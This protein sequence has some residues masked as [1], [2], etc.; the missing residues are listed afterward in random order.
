MGNYV[1]QVVHSRFP[2]SERFGRYSRGKALD[3]GPTQ[4]EQRSREKTPSQRASGPTLRHRTYWGT[5]SLNDI[6]EPLLIFIKLTSDELSFVEYASA[7]ADW[8]EPY[9]DYTRPPPSV[10]LAEAAKQTELKTGQ[11]LK[12]VDMLALNGAHGNG[13][14][15]EEAPTVK[16]PPEIAVKFFDCTSCV[17]FRAIIVENHCF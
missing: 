1:P 4:A 3:W 10:V 15:D 7:L 6:L 13:K 5:L 17:H 16:E 12:G 11:P 14:K 2:A 8:L 9:H